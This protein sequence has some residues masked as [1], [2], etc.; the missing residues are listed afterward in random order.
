MADKK[1]HLTRQEEFEL[2]KA[3]IDKLL[4]VGVFFLVF[5]A[6]EMV[7]KDFLMGFFIALSGCV[8]MLLFV[9][10]LTREFEYAKR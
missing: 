9:W 4:W 8:I 5:G 10:I 6:V 7:L 1:R 3:M 2:M